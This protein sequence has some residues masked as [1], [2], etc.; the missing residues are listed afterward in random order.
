MKL[1][2]SIVAL[3]LALAL[4][5]SSA[6]AAKGAG[7]GGKGSKPVKGTVVKV[8]GTNIVVSAK[9]KAGEN[10]VTVA[11]DNST[12]FENNGAAGTLADVKPGKRVEITP[13]SGTAQKVVIAAGKAGKGG[14]KNK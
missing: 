8:D 4:T 10:E 13:G 11:T 6:L 2:L 5:S 14:K 3:S 7:K 1:L 9:T 12:Q